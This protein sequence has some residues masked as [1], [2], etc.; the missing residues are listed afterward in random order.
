MSRTHQFVAI[1]LGSLSALACEDPVRL[2]G[3]W[4]ASS[5]PL[6]KVAVTETEAIAVWHRKTSTLVAGEVHAAR[7]QTDGSEW[8]PPINLG[9][10][11]HPTVA[12]SPASRGLA[13]FDSSSGLTARTVDDGVWGARVTVTTDTPRSR[14]Y[15]VAVDGVGNGVVAWGGASTQVRA[16]SWDSGWAGAVSLSPNVGS[17]QRVASTADGHT[18][19]AWCEGTTLKGGRRIPPLGFW[20]LTTLAVNCCSSGGSTLHTNPVRISVSSSGDAMVIGTDES[21]RV[22]AV[23]YSSGAWESPVTLAAAHGSFP[24]IALNADG[25]ALAAWLQAPGSNLVARAY[26][27]GV[28][29]G[30]ALPGPT[31]VHTHGLGVGVNEFG[32]GAIIYTRS[33]STTEPSTSVYY[34]VYDQSAGALTAPTAIESMTGNS[35]YLSVA[36]TPTGKG[37][38]IWNQNQRAGAE[39]WV[40]LRGL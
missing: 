9:T 17:W 14:N 28:G 30:P 36:S 15:D 34:V 24:V 38:T 39:V 5:E 3:P 31:D 18:V 33:A 21:T 20:I 11:S 16:Y 2:E 4:S 23:R 7:Y 22:C 1:V 12:L 10:G 35:Y 19:A 32:S 25:D 6:P 8:T 29:W 13:V 27:A 40:A 37:V 26:T